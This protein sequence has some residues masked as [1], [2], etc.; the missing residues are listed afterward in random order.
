MVL[1][2]L[3]IKQL[4]ILSGDKFTIDLDTDITSELK[5]EGLIREVIR[6]VQNARKNAGLDVDNRINLSLKTDNKAL[7]AAIKQFENEIRSETLAKSITLSPK[8]H[9]EEVKVDNYKLTIG[10]E[11]APRQ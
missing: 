2:E 10:I 3:N 5:Q 6:H 7:E 8:K 4:E 1:E 11:K 9:N